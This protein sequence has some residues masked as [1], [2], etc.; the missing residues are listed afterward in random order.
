MVLVGLKRCFAL[1]LSRCQEN[2]LLACTALVEAFGLL[3][4]DY[5]IKREVYL[6]QVKFQNEETDLQSCHYVLAS[7]LHS[8]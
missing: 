7:K 6:D 4:G 3:H 1:G 2:I 8:G 5:G